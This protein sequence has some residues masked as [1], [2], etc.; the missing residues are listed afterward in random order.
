M[1]RLIVKL[2]VLNIV[3][4]MGHVEVDVL[5]GDIEGRRAVKVRA[6]VDTGATF[7]IIPEDIAGKLDLKPTGERV[8]VL[9]ARGYDELDL[10]HALIEIN[11][12]RRIMPVLVS[13]YIDRV[14]IGVITLEAM[15]LYVN[16][17]T[18][19]LEEST[20]LLY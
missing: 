15:Q 14:L 12:K 5:I 3:V 10:T 9:T 6:L 7:T 4:A 20:A 17:T 11:G 13:K 8:R 16:P 19:K 18:R 1:K 2:S